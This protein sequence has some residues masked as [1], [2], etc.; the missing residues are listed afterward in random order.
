MTPKKNNPPALYAVIMAGGS[1]R[2]FWPRSRKQRPKQLLALGAGG[3]LVRETLDRLLP[4]CPPRRI[5]VSCGRDIAAAI[6][7]ALPEVPQ[8]NFIIEPVGRDTAPC[9][10]LALQHLAAAGIADDAVM[11]V[12]PAD[13]CIGRPARFRS[14]LARAA[15]AARRQKLI[16]TIGIVPD[17]PSAA[18]GYIQPAAPAPGE[19]GARRVKR[20][21]EKPDLKTARRY[22]ERGFLWN[23][24]MFVFRLDVMREAYRKFLPDMAADLEKIGA[25]DAGTR[26]RIIARVFP[27]LRKVSIDYGIMEK[28]GN[29]AVVPGEFDWCD[30]GG[31]DALYRMQGGDGIKNI[32]QGPAEF[33]GSRGCYVES[34]KLAALVGVHGLVVIETDDAILILR[35]ESEAD[36]KKLT[37][38]LAAKG[39]ARL[40]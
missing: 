39:L 26:A 11:A 1:G 38:R 40:L 6:A 17:R 5:Y 9:V 25:T 3:P 18:Y 19:K 20:F 4:L 32:A 8:S 23:A 21:V 28:A 10:G 37:D 35:R 24:G 2:R 33:V 27:G 22:I 34:G 15:A 7:A 12:L 36:L 30:V 16:V 29:V 31:W 14:T 13:H